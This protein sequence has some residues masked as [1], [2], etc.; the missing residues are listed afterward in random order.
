MPLDPICKK[1]ISRDTEYFSDYG[2]KNYY[3]CSSECKHKFDALEKSVIRLKRNLSEK[4]K[5][6]CNYSGSLNEATHFSSFRG[7]I[8]YKM[9]PF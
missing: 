6:S 7:K 1:I 2:G 5:I 8:G 9:I 4:E 3:F